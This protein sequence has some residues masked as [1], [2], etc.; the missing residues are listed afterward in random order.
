M[1]TT[2]GVTYLE[3]ELMRVELT[4]SH[5]ISDHPVQYGG[6]G[7]GPS[8]GELLVASLVAA[9]VLGTRKAATRN[10][11]ELAGIVVR[12]ALRVDREGT[13]GPLDTLAIISRL[14]R[15]FELAGSLSEEE[16]YRLIDDLGFAARF[17]RGI[18]ISESV[19]FTLG[20][21]KGQSDD[22]VNQALQNSGTAESALAPG[23]RITA[24][25]S[26]WRVH[27][28]E[29]A[30]GLVVV[31]LSGAP[32]LVSEDGRFGSSTPSELMMA[33]LA[34]CTTIYVAR[35]GRFNDIPLEGVKVT[36][37]ADTSAGPPTHVEKRTWADGKLTLAQKAKA[38]FFAEFCAVGESLKRG[39]AVYNEIVVAEPQAAGPVTGDASYALA[40]LL[41]SSPACG[42]GSCCA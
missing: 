11:I 37:T 2:I 21:G 25:V 29:I 30:P 15:R 41:S 10:G 32:L 36:V 35:N 13:D 28:G 19:E 4:G 9:S 31:H 5:L 17:E 20:E 8:P 42:D 26:D 33:S 7:K 23:A 27:A 38:E 1:T 6:S 12:G 16:A 22:W 14:S 40:Q 34:T 3:R 18:A 39:I 24:D